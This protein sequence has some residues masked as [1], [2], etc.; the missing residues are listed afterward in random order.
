MHVKNVMITFRVGT[1]IFHPSCPQH[2]PEYSA[3]GYSWQSLALKYQISVFSCNF[4]SQVTNDQYVRSCWNDSLLS[5]ALKKYREVHCLP[6]LSHNLPSVRLRYRYLLSYRHRSMTSSSPAVLLIS[7]QPKLWQRCETIK[8]CSF[9]F[10]QYRWL[11]LGR[12]LAT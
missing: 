5:I 4:T 2:Y 9:S 10:N 3:Q 12:P 1:R 11:P 7:I 6:K 8:A